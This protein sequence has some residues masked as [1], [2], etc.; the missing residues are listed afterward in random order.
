MFSLIL[1]NFR[2]Y[3]PAGGQR[4]NLSFLIIYHSIIVAFTE[5]SKFQQRLEGGEGK[6]AQWNSQDIDPKA[7]A[8]LA[9]SRCMCLK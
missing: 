2:S 9:S 4:P 1:K 7:D 5:K 6:Q 3:P 8:S